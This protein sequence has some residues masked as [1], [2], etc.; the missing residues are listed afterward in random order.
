VIP[1]TA[2][3]QPE[4]RF[5]PMP[6]NFPAQLIGTT[7]AAQIVVVSDDMDRDGVALIPLTTSGDFNVVSAG[8]N[9]C[10][11][12]PAL[13]SGTNCTL[14][15]TFTPHQA[16]PTSGAVTFT[17]YPECDPENVLLFHEPCPNAQVVN[18]TGT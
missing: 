10:G 5:N 14:G 17:L 13:H 6:V 12:S 3:I 11:L 16:G 8:A 4:I 1:L 9:P 2:S 15:I 18:L 7:S